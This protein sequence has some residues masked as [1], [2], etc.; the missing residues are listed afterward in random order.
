VGF[1]EDGPVDVGP[2]VLSGQKLKARLA[3]EKSQ[4]WALAG[5]ERRM[6]HM[7]FWVGAGGQMAW[8]SQPKRNQ[9][10]ASRPNRKRMVVRVRIC[11][12]NCRGLSP[13][14]TRRSREKTVETPTMKMKKG[15]MRSARVQPFQAACTNCGKRGVSLQTRRLLTMIM[16]PMVAPRK[17]SRDTS[18]LGDSVFMATVFSAQR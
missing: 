15:K 6:A 8:K 18:R 13:A 4:I 16:A 14:C 12:Y 2:Q 11:R 17:I 9:L 3:R 5:G 7:L 1:P 10:Q